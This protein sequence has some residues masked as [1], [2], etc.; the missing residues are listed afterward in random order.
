[1]H[2]QNMKEEGRAEWSQGSSMPYGAIMVRPE[3]SPESRHGAELCCA[4]VDKSGLPN[5]SVF[6]TGHSKN[7]GGED[8]CPQCF[9]H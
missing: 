5:A 1:M 7:A 4:H 9:Q 3:N 2:E 6:S 8:I